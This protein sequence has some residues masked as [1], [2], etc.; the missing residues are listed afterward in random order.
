MALEGNLSSF[1]LEEILQLIAVQQKTGMLSVTINE[2]STVLFFRD[3]KIISTRDRRSKTRDPFRE[4]LMRYGVLTREE[5]VRLTQIGTQSKL[6]LFEIL[7]SERFLD[8]KTLAKQ[9]RYHIQ[10]TLHDVLTWDQCS[11]KF[12]SGEEIV[13]GVRSLGEHIVEPLLMECMRRI[14]EYPMLQEM[15]PAEGIRIGPTGRE[16]EP[17][18]EMF[19]SERSVLAGLKTPRAVRDII[20]RAKMPAFDT[21]E[22]LKLLK[23]KGLVVVEADLSAS[24][25]APGASAAAKA[26]RKHGNPLIIMACLIV[27]TVCA[28]VGAMHD[29]D[30]AAAIAR[31]GI[32]SNDAAHRSRIEYHVRWLI[33]AYRARNGVYPDDLTELWKSG[34]ADN[35]TIQSASSLELRYKLTSDKLA[36]TLL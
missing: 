29:A 2:K 1:G 22:A 4:Y 36:Y 32:L 9:W 15:F 35:D 31:N 20:A 16:P 24:A 10:E 21:Y 7:T 27:F 19:E 12:I 14:D 28:F 13:G 11:Y 8:E 17:G 30:R 34:L 18:A 26:R 3:G 25:D 23:E 6:D 33:E 5:L